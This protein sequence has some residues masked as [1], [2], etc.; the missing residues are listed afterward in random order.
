LVVLEHLHDEEI[1]FSNNDSLQPLPP[2]WFK[3]DDMDDLALSDGAVD[4]EAE[5]AGRHCV[6]TRC[7]SLSTPRRQAVGNNGRP[8]EL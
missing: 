1:D 6:A 4:D 2:E 5:V 7:C 8:R 3:T